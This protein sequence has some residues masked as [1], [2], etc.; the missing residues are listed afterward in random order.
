[1]LNKS[2][3]TI[4]KTKLGNFEIK[5][6]NGY[7]ISFYPSID[8]ESC[9]L[10]FYSKNIKIEINDYLIGKRQYFS[11]KIN[12]S[13]SLFQKKVWSEISNIRYGSTVSYLNMANKLS[14]SPRAI[15]N[16]CSKNS[17]LFFI[18]CH[19]VVGSNNSIGGF[20][21]GKNIKS[22]LLKIEKKHDFSLL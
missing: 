2:N 19:R 14:T 12:P 6:K 22:N 9:S 20:V 5:F 13:G 1:M 21:M 4:I 16:A 11:N 7:I 18:P 17:C 10:D 3:T 15:G 8:T